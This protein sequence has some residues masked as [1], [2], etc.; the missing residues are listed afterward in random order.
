MHR[1]PT[2]VADGMATLHRSD[3]LFDP[4]FQRAYAAGLA[5][6]HRFGENLHIEWR[7]YVACWAAEHAL[8]V[9]GDFVEC[10]VNTGILSRA[11]VEYV[12]FGARSDRIF[13]LLDTFKGIPEESALPEEQDLVAG[14]NTLYDDCLA[15]VET[16]F[17]PYDNVR[18]VP[19]LVPGTLGCV[20]S[21][22]IAFLSLDMNNVQP[23]MAALDF[24]WSRLVPGGVVVLD[25]YGFAGHELQRLGMDE[26]A[27]ELG[28]TILALPTGQGLIFKT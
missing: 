7:V 27:A 25:D 4:R 19:G 13:W 11:I 8:R 10:G 6:G 2:F 26:L 12:D 9:G 3:F 22:R 28:T 1:K 16:T 17:A 24:F 21:E 14:M 15:Q 5:T 23:E 18:I 20:T